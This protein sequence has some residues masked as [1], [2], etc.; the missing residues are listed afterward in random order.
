MFFAAMIAAA[1]VMDD[2]LVVVDA[3]LA[4]IPKC[5]RLCAEMRRTIEHCRRV[6]FSA[7]HFEG[8]FDDIE[9]YLGHYHPVHT[10]NS[11]ALVMAGF[12]LGD[13]DFGKTVGLAVT[14]GWEIDAAAPRP[15]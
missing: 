10:N 1:F 14:G 8:V 6:G 9:R 4:E 5:W 15:V 11:A 3:G 2:P 12:L 7:D 13:G